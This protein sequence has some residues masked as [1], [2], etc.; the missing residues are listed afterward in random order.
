MKLKPLAEQVVVVFGA[1]S[2][3][4]RLTALEFA[5]RGAK[6]VVAARSEEGLRSLVDEIKPFGGEATPVVADAAEVFE[7]KHVAEVAEATYGRLDTWAHVAGI[8]LVAPFEQTTPEE[9]KRVVEVNLCGQAYGAMAALPHIRKAG[10]GALIHVSSVE[11][12]VSFPEQ[13]AYAASKHGVAGMLDTLRMELEH[14]GVPISVTNILPASIDTPLFDKALTKIGVKPKGAP[15]IYPPESVAHA[16]L[17]AAA[18]PTREIYVGGAGKFLALSKRYAPAL[19]DRMI[20]T[21]MYDSFRTEE[22]KGADAPSAVFEEVN[23]N[24][25]RG[26]LTER[27]RRGSFYT[28]FATHKKEVLTAGVALSALGVLA[29]SARGGTNGSNGA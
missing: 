8:Y 29:A 14:E 28:W 17:H 9:F 26:S 6:V 15:P 16:I 1:S 2:G 27:S 3:I 4:G 24:R 7:V 10:G 12:V 5:R 13:S 22:P 21:F 18:H 25:V 20:R 19:T 23:D 11:A